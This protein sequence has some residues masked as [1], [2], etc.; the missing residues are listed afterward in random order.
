MPFIGTRHRSDNNLLVTTKVHGPT[1]RFMFDPKDV[2]KEVKRLTGEEEAPDPKR[3]AI[4]I[5]DRVADLVEHDPN[6]I[7]L[8]CEVLGADGILYSD[9][10]VLKE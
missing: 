9:T 5:V 2:L 1:L 3:L 10:V 4:T 8:E 6:A 7:W